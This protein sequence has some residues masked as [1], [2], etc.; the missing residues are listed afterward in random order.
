MQR[1]DMQNDDANESGN[2]PK[3]LSYSGLAASPHE[4]EITL[5]ALAFLALLLAVLG[6]GVGYLLAHQESVRTSEA[7]SRSSDQVNIEQFKMQKAGI[8][9]QEA[10]Q[11]RFFDIQMKVITD[12]E[13]KGNIPVWA[14]GNVD[15]K[16]TP[17]R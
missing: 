12:C 9:L 10:Q 17:A 14:N 7:A 8:D 11:K 1:K 3:E 2:E 5:P 15:C 4:P 16:V 6:G 13:T